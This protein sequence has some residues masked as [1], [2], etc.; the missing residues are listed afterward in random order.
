M[1][2]LVNHDAGNVLKSLEVV[3]AHLF[4]V[5]SSI[6]RC[7]LIPL[8]AHMAK[9]SMSVSDFSRSELRFSKTVVRLHYLK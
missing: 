8:C 6:V 1:N 4:S 2:S 3:R 5:H 7:G 9:T